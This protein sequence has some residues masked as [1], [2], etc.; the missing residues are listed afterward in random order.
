MGQ[1]GFHDF[2][3]RYEGLDSKRDPL[4][5]LNKLVPWE[6]FRPQLHAALLAG[7][8]PKEWADKS[9]KRRQKDR[10]ARWT[11]KHGRSYFGYKNHVCTDRKHKFI[12]RYTVSD[13]ACHDS[14]KFEEVLDSTNSSADT[15][16]DSTYNSQAH[17]EMLKARGLRSR[18]H[19]RGARN[20]PLSEREK[21]GNKT[22]SRVRARVE[23]ILGH[24][25]TAIKNCLLVD[26]LRLAA[27]L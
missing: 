2:S 15:W 8:T 24:Q 9:A 1:M 20:H 18:V 21:A 25:V 22:R 13:A 6:A 11:K 10:D 19:R 14:Q 16:A 23:H 4:P 27:S 26:S 12:R 5:L 3:R 17:E 7:E